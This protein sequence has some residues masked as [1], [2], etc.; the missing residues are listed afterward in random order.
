MLA[1]FPKH[2]IG[3]AFLSEIEIDFSRCNVDQLLAMIQRD[4]R[5][6]VPFLVAGGIGLLFCFPRLEAFIDE[7]ALIQKERR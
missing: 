7:S 2:D 1:R 3:P 5:Q 4:P 6:F